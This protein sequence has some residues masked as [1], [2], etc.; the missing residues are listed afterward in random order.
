MRQAAGVFQLGDGFERVAG[1]QVRQIAAV[2]QLQELDDEFDVADAAVAGFDVAVVGPF[3]LA[4]LLDAA[5]EGFDA[6]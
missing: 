2:E 4:A 6:A 1:A 5:F 3:A